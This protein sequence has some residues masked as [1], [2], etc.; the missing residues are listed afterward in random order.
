MD[1]NNISDLVIIIKGA[2]EMATGVAC[3]L[4]RANIRKIL[5]LEMPSP[6]AI[7]RRVSFCEAVHEGSWKVEDIGAVKVSTMSE[8]ENIWGLGKIAIMVDPEG[9]SIKSVTSDVLIDATLAKKNT[10]LT[11]EDAG[12]VIAL[13]PG[14][15]AGKDCNVVIETN[16]GHNL[17]R[18]IYSGS[19]EPDTGIPGE[20]NGHSSERLL[21]APADGIFSGNKTIG[22]KV[23]KGE[24][25]GY[26]GSGEV[27]ANVSGIIRGLITNGT[28]VTSGLKIGDIDPRGEASYCNTI[29][30]KA[31]ALGG[32]VLEA[33]LAFYNGKEGK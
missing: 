7:R 3:G 26:C 18:L 4:Y 11:K 2:G 28:T 29:S 16:R 17:G 22:D 24:V 32:S 23:E 12:L 20:I 33:V 30:D 27:R 14:F 10:G 9:K 6:L 8:I 25:I 13:G 1:R 19:A 15:L 21:R 31:R 5:M